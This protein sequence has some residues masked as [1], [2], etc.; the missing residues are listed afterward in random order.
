M[1]SIFFSFNRHHVINCVSDNSEKCMRRFVIEQREKCLRL[2]C[3]RG[4][5]E[6]VQ[7]VSR[8]SFGCFFCRL[9]VPSFIRWMAK[10]N[11]SIVNVKRERWANEEKEGQKHVENI[12]WN[13]IRI[14]FWNSVAR[15]VRTT[16]TNW[17]AVTDL[18]CETIRRSIRSDDKR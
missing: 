16:L 17:V 18:P 13:W 8:R 14:T 12:L 1:K 5:Y 10:C 7:I 15:I 11:K 6:T 2:Q 3:K 9:S 4:K